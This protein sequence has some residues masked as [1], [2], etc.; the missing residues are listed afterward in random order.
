[1]SAVQ[2]WSADLKTFCTMQSSEATSSA[3]HCSGYLYITDWKGPD[4]YRTGSGLVGVA[5]LAHL[6]D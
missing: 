1:M 2:E 3:L 4:K 5:I 6:K